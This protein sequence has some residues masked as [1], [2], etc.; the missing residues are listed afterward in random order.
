VNEK[1]T[2]HAELSDLLNAAQA[3]AVA[4]LKGEY[5]TPQTL[6]KLA[7]YTKFAIFEQVLLGQW[8]PIGIADPD[9]LLELKVTTR[10]GKGAEP[11]IVIEYDFS[12][13]SKP[14]ICVEQGRA[15]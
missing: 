8:H 15:G 6:A 12:R 4:E 11:P 3:C 7:T 2:K 13:T 9:D 1:F 10:L 5:A 14:Y